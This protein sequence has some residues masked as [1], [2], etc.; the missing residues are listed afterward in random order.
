MVRKML[1]KVKALLQR[2]KRAPQTL[3]NIRERKHDVVVQLQNYK[4]HMAP[5]WYL[6][7]TKMAHRIGVVPPQD[8]MEIK[9]Y[10]FVRRLGVVSGLKAW[11]TNYLVPPL[12]VKIGNQ[13]REPVTACNQLLLTSDGGI[14]LF[15]PTVV[16]I[17]VPDWKKRKRL[18]EAHKVLGEHL[19]VTELRPLDD[20]ELL[21]ETFVEG[22]SWHLMARDEQY[23][24]YPLLLSMITR[25]TKETSRA[26][27]GI[28]AAEDAVRRAL[29]ATVSFPVNDLIRERH[30][31]ISMFL[32]LCP[33]VPSHGDMS[34]QNIIVGSNRLYIIDLERFAYLPFF[35]DALKLPVANA[36]YLRSEDLVRAVLTG[37]FDQS[38]DTLFAAAGVQA[39]SAQRTVAMLSVLVVHLQH[40]LP[41]PITEGKGRRWCAPF[42]KMVSVGRNEMEASSKRPGR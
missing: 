38:L 31:E 23:N 28:N 25:L 13:L 9:G 2:L 8:L 6:V 24:A 12:M 15:S 3:S 26:L 7:T 17:H 27:Y 40:S 39:F 34:G 11:V 16:L 33:V 4:P 19:P 5:G 18:M 32:A 35:Y 30:K 20:G 42:H 41:G 1:R 36:L 21:E 10:R 14:K 37:K 29:M 22:R